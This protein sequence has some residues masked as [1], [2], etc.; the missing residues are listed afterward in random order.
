M[1]NIIPS[2]YN[3]WNVVY[4]IFVRATNCFSWKF[5]KTEKKLLQTGCLTIL[6]T[7]PVFIIGVPRTGS[8]F[9]YQL[10]TNRYDVSYFDNLVDIMH[11]FPLTGFYLS[12][13]IYGNK[14]HNCFK[15]KSGHTI[16]YGLHCPSEA[17]NYWYRFFK[18]K[19]YLVRPEDL[20]YATK[21]QIKN[22]IESVIKRYD[23]PIVI[24]NLANS[25]RLRLIKE[26]FPNAKIIIIDRNIN[27]TTKSIIKNR[28]NKSVSQNEFWSI[29]PPEIE[30]IEF[31]N[32]KELI[33]QQ[34]NA[35]KA[36]I[37]KDIK[38]FSPENVIHMRYENLINTPAQ[39]LTVLDQF[40]NAKLRRNARLPSNLK[41][42]K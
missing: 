42:Q 28:K 25:L 40:M 14:P 11:S 41:K 6:T 21:Q 3:F 12:Y 4:E 1:I 32:E 34:I 23:K 33:H 18:K 19:Q 35:I 7:Q 24:K 9:F 39:V 26:L 2:K 17:G 5:K 16:S 13:K 29:Y 27:D 37:K 22:E 20:D 15:S 36:Y 10:I 8:T 30:N 38:L 31:Q